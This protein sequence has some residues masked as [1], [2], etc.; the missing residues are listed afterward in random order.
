[1]VA[2]VSHS[3]RTLPVAAALRDRCESQFA[4]PSRDESM[5]PPS[6]LAAHASSNLTYLSPNRPQLFHTVIHRGGFALV[7]QARA[8]RAVWQAVYGCHSAANSAPSQAKHHYEKALLSL[9]HYFVSGD[10]EVDMLNGTLPPCDP[11]PVPQLLE[12]EAASQQLAPTE[13]MP[14]GP[15]VPWGGAVPEP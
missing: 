5:G 6:E 10:F 8:W 2:M 11:E 9:E 14:M 3:Y 12:P 13:L 15:D 7:N 4:L 1:M